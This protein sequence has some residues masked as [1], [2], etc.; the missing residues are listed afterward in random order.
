ME[1]PHTVGSI[2]L[3]VIL[4]NAFTYASTASAQMNVNYGWSLKIHYVL[5]SEESID[6]CVLPFL[7][8]RGIH[9]TPRIDWQSIE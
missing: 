4:L 7:L 3:Y 9:Q 6:L 2:C 8:W 1:S 5:L